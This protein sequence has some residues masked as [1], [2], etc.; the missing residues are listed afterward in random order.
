MHNLMVLGLCN[1]ETSLESKNSVGIIKENERTKE[2][3]R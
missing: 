3:Q 1:R 2:G